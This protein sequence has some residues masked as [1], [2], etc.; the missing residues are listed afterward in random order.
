MRSL[1]HA[2]ETTKVIAICNR[3]KTRKV[4]RT[5]QVFDETSV[6]SRRG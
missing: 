5:H 3:K 2:A 4:A 6:D 1:K